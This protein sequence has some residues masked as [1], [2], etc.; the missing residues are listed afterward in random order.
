MEVRDIIYLVRAKNSATVSSET[1]TF[2]FSDAVFFSAVIIIIIV[3][4]SCYYIFNINMTEREQH[5]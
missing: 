2:L 4:V 3:T 1:G 5:G